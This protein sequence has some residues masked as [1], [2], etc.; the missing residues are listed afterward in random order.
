MQSIQNSRTI[1]DA[2]ILSRIAGNQPLITDSSLLNGA[3][4][5]SACVP[6][7]P[8]ASVAIHFDS[9]SRRE[10]PGCEG[11]THFFEHLPPAS[12]RITHEGQNLVKFAEARKWDIKIYIGQEKLTFGFVCPDYEAAESMQVLGEMLCNSEDAYRQVFPIEKGRILNEI[13]QNQMKAG[14]KSYQFLTNLLF[15]GTGYAHPVVGTSEQVAEYEFQKIM[16]LGRSALSPK[17]ATVAV[18]GPE[19]VIEQAKTF[20][21][22]MPFRGDGAAHPRFELGELPNWSKIPDVSKHT[23]PLFSD[24]EIQV[25]LPGMKGFD[26]RESEALNIIVKDLSLQMNAVLSHETGLSYGAGMG[27][28]HFA[29]V[30][31]LSA[32]TNVN[33]KNVSRALEVMGTL[34]RDF[35]SQLSE[36]MLHDNYVSN[37][38]SAYLASSA[39][40]YGPTLESMAAVPER[41]YVTSVERLRVLRSLKVEELQA[42]AEKYLD[43]SKM[44]IIFH[45][46]EQALNQIA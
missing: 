34:Q 1:D 39:L 40:N 24:V 8:S 22:A 28:F 9:G 43:P 16:D 6:N 10:L 25:L 31:V 46:S 37:R 35:K 17:R 2:A 4:F 12:F 36:Q 13:N 41:P 5:L 42:V 29:D 38:N 32:G 21:E 15:S 3:R 27:Q 14:V 11:A 45:G 19:G 20:F 30:G 7:Y 23:C 33:P 18:S 26:I 44:R